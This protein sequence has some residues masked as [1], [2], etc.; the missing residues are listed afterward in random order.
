MSPVDGVE[1]Q[2]C[3]PPFGILFQWSLM[4]PT[5]P[6]PLQNEICFLKVKLKALFDLAPSHFS[7]PPHNFSQHTL[8][9]LWKEIGKMS[10]HTFTM[11]HS[12]PLLQLVSHPEYP[13]PS[14][15]H[16]LLSPSRL[17]LFQEASCPNLSTPALPLH[18][19]HPIPLY[20][21]LQP[22]P[23]LPTQVNTPWEQGP[24]LPQIFP[25]SFS[26]DEEL[27]SRGWLK[28]PLNLR[29]L[30]RALLEW[31]AISFSNARKWKVKVKSLSRV[32]LLA[33]PW[34]AAHQAPPSM[35]F[36]RQEYWSGVP[37]PSPK[38]Y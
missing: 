15:V 17:T 18:G 24:I 22:S 30:Q 3:F 37:L 1:L 38:T 28:G 25:N 10:Q 32:R 33:T 26:Q 13:L 7:G 4:L 8:C 19:P 27:F 2:V 31:V 6:H 16:G 12:G 23:C 36:S 34:T 9:T 29:P 35:G 5:P 20:P 21:N 14:P 11:T